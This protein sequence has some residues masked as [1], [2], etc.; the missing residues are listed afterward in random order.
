MVHFIT[1]VWFTSGALLG[2]GL[3]YS[4]G[5]GLGTRTAWRPRS[6]RRCGFK[7]ELGDRP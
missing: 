7:P 1:A 2:T 5:A 3:G 4:L 6:R